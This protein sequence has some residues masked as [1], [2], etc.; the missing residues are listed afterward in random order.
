MILESQEMT[1]GVIVLI[2]AACTFLTRFLPF[3]L[4][5]GGKEVPEIVRT[6]GELLPP[7]VIAILVI[8]CLKGVNFTIPPN[9]IPEFIGVGIVVALHIWK[10]NNLLSIGGGTIIYMI[11][12]QYLF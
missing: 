8:Y 4:F 9:G 11:L 5:G 1:A 10:R 2:V 12:V 3:A 7:A 6:L